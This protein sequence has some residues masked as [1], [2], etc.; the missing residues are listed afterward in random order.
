MVW[1]RLL[2]S[3]GCVRN[4][5]ASQVARRVNDVL[6]HQSINQGAWDRLVVTGSPFSKVASDAE[7]HQP[8][9]H[10]D[11]R[12]WLPESVRGL[13]VLCLA[14]GGGW[15]STL[16][17]VAGA[18]VTV[19]DLCREMLQQDLREAERRGVQVR[20]L[21]ASMDDLSA[22]SEASFDIVHQP[23]STC[24]VPDILRVYQE[25]ARVLVPGGLYISQHKQPT[26]LQ[27][28]ERDNRD[29]YVL[30]IPYYHT[31]PLPLG[32]DR[33]Y[34]EAG[35]VEFLHR[36]EDLVGGLA[37]SGLVLEDLREPSRV[38]AGSGPGE[39]GH[40]GQFT[41][42]YVRMKARKPSAES[43]AAATPVATVLW[44]PGR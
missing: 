40:R 8:L 12:G 26:S 38:K 4:R 41:P 21:Q 16:Y 1:A 18:E 43:P 33:T 15:Q 19:V 23:V 44:T 39:I 5:H 20:T 2:W 28:T 35:T 31:G 30:G 6:P 7:C 29:R 36:W 32:A 14:A 22:V 34:R 10:L 11:G 25:V 9:W 13:R 24:Y 37:R 27:V 42:P 17:A 3:C